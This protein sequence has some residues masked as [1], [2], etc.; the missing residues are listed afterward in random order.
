M[1]ER[2]SGLIGIIHIVRGEDV[3]QI[4]S[5]EAM[6]RGLVQC[7]APRVLKRVDRRQKDYSEQLLDFPLFAE[8][9][10]RDTVA[11][12]AGDSLQEMVGSQP[13]IYIPVQFYKKP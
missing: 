6:V 4:T 2:D 1:G 13:Q 12:V 9:I 10:P 8:E 3:N 5:M 7:G 11:L